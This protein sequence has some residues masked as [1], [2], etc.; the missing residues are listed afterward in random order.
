MSK[1][2]LAPHNEVFTIKNILSRA[3]CAECIALSENLGY[4]EVPITPNRAF[5]RRPNIRNSGCVKL[6]DPKSASDLWKRV[7]NYIPSKIGE[8]RAIGLNEHFRFY[9]YNPGQRFTIHYDDSYHRPNGEASLLTFMIYLNEDF[10]GGETCFYPPYDHA[11]ESSISV[12]PA[13]GMALCF[14]HALPHEGAP[15]IRGR[16]YV[17]RSDVMYRAD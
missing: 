17:L 12:V 14:V 4:T 3:E 10:E 13:I 6:D 7:S 2:V 15:V 1:N 5:E 11:R 9:R 8:W 16:K